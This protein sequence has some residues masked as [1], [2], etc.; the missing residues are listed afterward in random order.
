MAD[1]E[2]FPMNNANPLERAR[3]HMAQV[4]EMTISSWA[5]RGEAHLC[6]N[7]ACLLSSPTGHR[8]KKRTRGLH[9]NH[10]L[11]NFDDVKLVAKRISNVTN[12]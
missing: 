6:N 9:Q 11:S 5:Q 3:I 10:M 7:A 1:N 2:T 8:L 12:N 4:S